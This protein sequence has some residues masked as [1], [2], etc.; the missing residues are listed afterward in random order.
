MQRSVATVLDPTAGY[1]LRPCRG[2]FAVIIPEATQNL[3][4]NPSFERDTVG[5]APALWTKV[6]GA[7][8]NLEVS[9]LYQSRGAQSCR[10]QPDPG[11]VSGVFYGP[12]TT[13]SGKPYTF[14]IDYLGF[15][16]NPVDIY[17]ADSGGGQLGAATRVYGNGRWQRPSV[18]YYEQ[19][20][21]TR[22]VYFTMP[23]A[24]QIP[25]PISHETFFLD[26]AQ[27]EEKGY[28][29]TYTDGDQRG[30]IDLPGT[31]AY[32][33][34]G[35]AHASTSRRAAHT[36]AGGRVRLLSDMGLVVTAYIGLRHP[37]VRNVMYDYGYLDGALYQKTGYLARDFAIVGE[38]VAHTWLHGK[39]QVEQLENAF[40]RDAVP[41]DQ[42][43]VLLFQ[44]L[45]EFGHVVGE[46]KEIV[47]VYAGGLEGLVDNDYQG[48]VTIAFVAPR[49]FARSTVDRA[50]ALT[51][52]V[53]I[54]PG[55]IMRRKPDGNW[56]NLGGGVAGGSPTRVN[57]ILVLPDGRY[58]VAGQFQTAGGN[59]ARNLALYDPLTGTWSEAAN[60]N[61]EVL[62]LTLGPDGLVY[63]GGSFTLVNG[64]TVNRIGSLNPATLAV[65]QVGGGADNGDVKD[66]EHTVDGVLYIVGSFTAVN[67]GTGANRIAKLPVGAGAFKAIG[68]GL[69]GTGWALSRSGIAGRMWVGG[70][71]ATADG[72]TVNNFTY[73]DGTTFYALPTTGTVGTNGLV[74]Q[75]VCIPFVGVF[76]A[77]SFTTAGGVSCL[78]IAWWDKSQYY[79]LGSG[80]ALSNSSLA[81]GPNGELWADGGPTDASPADDLGFWLGNT[82]FPNDSNWV[83]DQGYSA[84]TVG[85]DGLLLCS[86]VAEGSGSTWGAVTVVTN[87]GSA[88]TYPRV[89]I[90]GPTSGSSAAPVY[91]L[92]NKTNGKSIY[93]KGLAVNVGETLTLDFTPGLTRLESDFRGDLSSYILPGSDQNTFVLEP[94]DNNIS[95]FVDHESAS[96]VMLWREEYLSIEG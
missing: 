16:N 96:V 73:T 40:K 92:H 51:Q 42:P 93:F 3:I 44:P 88:K 86:N 65:A 5:N 76:L 11:A 57:D 21:G 58:L 75:L 18:T 38:H 69:S 22:R 95:V 68:S 29:T 49:P 50:K 34:E 47:A 1:I 90:K 26:G 36:R 48:R 80:L 45:T 62:C 25:M 2:F 53:Q 67:G 84:V 17:F 19:T 79:A 4:K 61:A 78:R 87:R 81:L 52:R 8:V 27:V 91:T 55:Y 54:N 94:G 77:G 12:I 66:V 74:E 59:T 70:L 72:V 46:E 35:S 89:I 6:G 71:F 82:W 64:G 7:G 15:G 39:K 10:V 14:S 31:P 23:M 32:W 13:S 33:W 9:N 20:G 41:Y 83:G 30:L 63:F 85:K 60:C 56:D 24:A 28:A 43:L 37:Q